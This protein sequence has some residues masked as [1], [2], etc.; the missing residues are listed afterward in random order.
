MSATT[1]KPTSRLIRYYRISRIA[2]HTLSGVAIAAL[3]MPM[4][5]KNGRLAIIKWW[6]KS[7]LQILNVRVR[8]H[9]KT[10]P[11]Y[12]T[13]RNNLLV[14]NHISWL[15]IHAINSILPV[16][17]IAKADIK[18]WPLF[19][20]LAKKSHVL[21]IER[22]K[23]QHAPRIVD[24]TRH[25]LQ[26]GDNVCFFP[27]GTTTDG[28]TILPFK[29]S[30]MESALQAKSTIWPIAIRYPR[31]DG[32]INTEVAYAGETTLLESIRCVLQQARPVLELYFLNP[33]VLDSTAL[34]P[35]VL[36]HIVGQP[37]A[38]QAKRRELTQLIQA[39]I[40]KQ[41]KL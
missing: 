13:A 12:Q 31:M 25:C 18:A 1:H 36:D 40:T 4:L 2:Y 39:K 3:I 8:V 32:S 10:P 37:H 27:E 15:D 9:G 26:A 20:Y 21:F 41:L 33:I 24:A 35:I 34:N 6:S 16:R 30:V 19:G 14:A 23:R 17:F 7:L 11:S 5:S 38:M 28:T 29:S 22:G